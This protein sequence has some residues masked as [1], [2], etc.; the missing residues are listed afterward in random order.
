MAEDWKMRPFWVPVTAL[1]QLSG[2]QALAT[3]KEALEPRTR[4]APRSFIVIRVAKREEI[5][6][7]R[8][9]ERVWKQEF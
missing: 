8:L 5:I 1:A 6:P 2:L 9:I 7:R 4:S 3:A